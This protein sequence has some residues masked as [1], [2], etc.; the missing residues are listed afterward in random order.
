[1]R[2]DRQIMIFSAIQALLLVAT[3]VLANIGGAVGYWSVF[4]TLIIGGWF[5]GIIQGCVY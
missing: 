2:V 1:M 5:C 4:M 3:P